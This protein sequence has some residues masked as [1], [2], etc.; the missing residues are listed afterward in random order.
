MK[1]RV[2][3]LF[4]NGLVKLGFCS[5]HEQVDAFSKLARKVVDCSSE[6]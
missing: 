4:D 6:A 2:V 1:K 3:E 5:F